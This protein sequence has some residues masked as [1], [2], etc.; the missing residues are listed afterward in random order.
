MVVSLIV[1]FL[2]LPLALLPQWHNKGLTLIFC[3]LQ[4]FALAW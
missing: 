4:Y 1:L 2:P 3:I